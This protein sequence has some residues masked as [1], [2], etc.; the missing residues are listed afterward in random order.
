[1]LSLFVGLAQACVPELPG[2][3]AT[4]VESPRYVLAYRTLPAK[5]TVGQHFS[6]EFALCAQSGV[7]LPESL[8]VDATMPEHRHGMNYKASVIP[9]APGRYR[10]D[11]LMFH[12]AGRWELV[13][14]LRT[15][16]KTDRLTQ[17]VVVD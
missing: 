12:M 6:V 5:I 4:S 1:L 10:A 11:G 2:A 8:K 14:E 9:Q 7:P 17:T 13:F 16:S 15:G 3:P